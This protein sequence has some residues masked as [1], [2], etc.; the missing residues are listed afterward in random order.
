MDLV[1]S[2]VTLTAFA[3]IAGAF[4]LWRRQGTTKQVSLMLLLAF[5]MIANVVIWTV[6][7]AE[8]DPAAP[9]RSAV[10]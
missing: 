9:P 4:F 7:M 10:P 6:P 2:L 1:L 5:I 3:L 8:T